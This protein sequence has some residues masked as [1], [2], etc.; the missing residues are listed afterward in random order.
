VDAARVAQLDEQV[1]EFP[2]GYDTLLGERGINLSGG[3]KQRATLARALARDPPSWSSTTRSAPWTRTPR[4][5]SSRT[6]ARS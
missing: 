1:E 4:P 2:Q 5:R 6:S 3:Q